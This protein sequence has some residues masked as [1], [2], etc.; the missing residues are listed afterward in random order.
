MW[1]CLF[2]FMVIFPFEYKQFAQFA[3]LLAEHDT[4]AGLDDFSFKDAFVIL[5]V[6][7]LDLACAAIVQA[8][9]D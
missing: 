6:D 7:E 3:H 2:V 4:D 8:I 1:L 9:F 5:V